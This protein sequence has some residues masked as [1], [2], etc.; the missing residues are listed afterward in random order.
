MAEE[1]SVLWQPS[2]ATIAASR[3]EHFRCHV[4]ERRGLELPTYQNLWRWSVEDIEGFWQ[5]LWTYYGLD[6]WSGY[7]SVL[8]KREMPGAEWF[9]GAR[10]NYAEQILA[11]G[12]PG[13]VA[14]RHMSENRPLQELGWDEFAE[15]VKRL[16]TWLRSAGVEPGDRVV[17]Y[18]P[19]IPETTIA[20][21]ATAAVGAVWS[22]CSPDFGTQSVIDRFGQIE[23]KVVFAV[24]GY[25][26]GGKDFDRRAIVGDLVD[27]LPSL[28]HVVVVPYL[29]TQAWQDHSDWIAWSDALAV[30]AQDFEFTRVA[31]DHPLW[32]LYSSG[33]TGL[34]KG[35]VHGQGGIILEHLKFGLHCNLNTESVFFCS[36]QPVGSCTTLSSVRC[37]RVPPRCSST[38][39]R[40]IPTS[41]PCG[42]WPSRPARLSSAPA[43][44]SSTRWR[45]WARPRGRSMIYRPCRASASPARRSAPKVS[46]GSIRASSRTCG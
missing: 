31:F 21:L 27:A 8:G 46:S 12:R 43:P 25:R 42:A 13:E 32:V 15:Q 23:P 24:D 3:V 44:P 30:S 36:P 1:G 16:A 37:C 6:D 35:I 9:P 39:T 29:D 41:A 19:N 33:T 22:S 28:Q 2:E 10:L 14:I 7:E 40:R 4:E 5:E 26:Y 20:L 38:A 11:R 18:M 45:R 17:A 34:P